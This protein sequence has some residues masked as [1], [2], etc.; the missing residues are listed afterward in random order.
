MPHFNAS[1][2]QACQSHFELQKAYLMPD[3]E[4]VVNKQL[5][6][7]TTLKKDLLEKGATE[8]RGSRFKSEYTI[9]TSP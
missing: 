2:F 8:L 6:G 3:T 4:I 7:D 9:L 5:A 1:A